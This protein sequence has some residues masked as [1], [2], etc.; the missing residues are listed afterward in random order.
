MK[1][2]LHVV[3]QYGSIP[4]VARECWNGRQARLRILCPL[5]R[6]GSSP[7]SRMNKKHRVCCVLTRKARCFSLFSRFFRN[8]LVYPSF[9]KEG[10]SF[11]SK[12]FP[13]MDSNVRIEEMFLEESNENKLERRF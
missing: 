5:G 13:K 12:V 11:L 6:V 8:R 1:K 3:E 2:F 10:N 9:Y 7:I 4:F